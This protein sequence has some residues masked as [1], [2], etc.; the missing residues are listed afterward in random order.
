M[1]NVFAAVREGARSA[2]HFARGGR[3][4]D[5]QL[6]RKVNEIAPLPEKFWKR[7]FTFKGFKARAANRRWRAVAATEGTLGVTREKQARDAAKELKSGFLGR[8]RL[9]SARRTGKDAFER[10]A[11]LQHTI[12][13][14]DVGPV[15]AWRLRAVS[16]RQRSLQNANIAFQTVFA[17]SNKRQAVRAL[18]NHGVAPFRK[19]LATAGRV[20]AEFKDRLSAEQALDLA[21][22]YANRNSSRGK[23]MAGAFRREGVSAVMAAYALKRGHHR[24]LLRALDAVERVGGEEGRKTLLMG[25]WRRR[26]AKNAEKRGL[27]RAAAA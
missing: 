18:A 7:N 5:F 22:R 19:I 4:S 11:N 27:L 26:N 23:R 15:S 1:A 8:W 17:A 16:N 3:I 21:V 12:A 13:K 25:V 20:P 24:A 10:E 6:E 2:W 9:M 14:N